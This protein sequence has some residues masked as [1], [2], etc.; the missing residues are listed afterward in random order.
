[1]YTFFEHTAELGLEIEAS[2]LEE[3]L[4]E[5][6]Q[7]FAELVAGP[8]E[9]GG[10]PVSYT[11]ELPV[12]ERTLL[13]DWL[14]ELVFLADTESFVPDR[15]IGAEHDDE[16]IRIE[17]AGFEGEPRALVKAVTRHELVLAEGADGMWRGRVVF[18][19]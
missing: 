18:D 16:R 17:V 14:D 9:A 12:D 11:R 6:T 13:A 19:V 15:I 1:M 3:L 10:I 5:A 7:A 4:D 8:K 2:S